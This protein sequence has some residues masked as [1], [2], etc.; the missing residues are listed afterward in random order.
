ML[1]TESLVCFKISIA[2]LRITSI[3]YNGFLVFLYKSFAQKKTDNK[4]MASEKSAIAHYFNNFSA[5][6]FSTREF[7]FTDIK[8]IINAFLLS[9]RKY[10]NL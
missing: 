5:S 3:E 2:Y 10:R 1:I 4:M 6:V 8:K 9:L 7:Q